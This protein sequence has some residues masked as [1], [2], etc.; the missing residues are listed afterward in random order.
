MDKK[1]ILIIDDEKSF[2]ELVKKNLELTGDYEVR[3][4]NKGV[5]ALAAAREFKPDL[6]FLDV[7]MPDVDGTE[8]AERLKSEEGLKN[9]PLIFLTA[10]VKED[11]IASSQ[12][13]RGGQP[14]IAKPV[15]TEK[16]IEYINK[17]TTT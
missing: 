14:F 17:Y 1:K 4:E 12:G 13:V 15:T 8:V 10:I 11:E 6:I 3:T 7:I 2:N 16:L 5:L 9:I